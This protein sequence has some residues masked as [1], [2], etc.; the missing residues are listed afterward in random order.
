VFTLFLYT[1]IK[2]I[3]AGFVKQRAS[4]SQNMIGVG[5]NDFLGDV[6]H[7]QNSGTPNGG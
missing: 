4:H 3:F 1:S 5:F 7:R 2:G 6:L